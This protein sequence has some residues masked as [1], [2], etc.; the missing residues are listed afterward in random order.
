MARNIR[1]DIGIV[2][3]AKELK[4]LEKHLEEAKQGKGKLVFLTGEA[5][6]GKAHLVEAFHKHHQDEVLLVEAHVSPDKQMPYAPV[7][8]LFKNTLKL[9]IPEDGASKLRGV[10]AQYKDMAART[11]DIEGGMKQREIERLFNQGTEALTSAGKDTSLMVFMDNLQ[12]ADKDSL[13]FIHFL[14]RNTRESHIMLVCTYRPEEMEDTPEQ[15]H[16]LTETL[17]MMMM[18]DL[19]STI[20]LER[21]T[22]EE[23]EAFVS[24]L[25]EFS[26]L[27]EQFVQRVYSDT[28]GNPF[29]VRE[30]IKG[31][32]R[33]G[34]LDVE[35]EDWASKIDYDE[36]KMPSSIRE[37][38]LARVEKQEGQDADVLKTAA[39]L[40]STFRLDDLAAM[41][42]KERDDIVQ[43]LYRLTEDKIV[44]ADSDVDGLYHFDHTKIQQIIE[45]ELG[46][47]RAELHKKAGEI[48]E[49]LHSD[50]MDSVVYELAYHYSMAGVTAK[51]VRYAGLAAEK[52][53]AS[54]APDEAKRYLRMVVSALDRLEGTPENKAALARRLIHLADIE[55][56]GGEVEKALEHYTTAIVTAQESGSEELSAKAYRKLGHYHREKGKWEEAKLAYGKALEIAERIDNKEVIADTYRGLGKVKWRLGDFPGAEELYNKTIEIATGAGIKKLVGVAKIELGNVL[57]DVG[58]YEEGIVSYKES[59]DILLEL[60]DM[61]EAARAYNNMGE[62]YKHM[63]KMDMAI[64]CYEDCIETA[65]KVGDIRTMSYGLMNAAEVLAKKGELDKALDYAT[66]ALQHVKKLQE[67]YVIGGAHMVLGLIYSKKGD[68]QQARE[69]FELSLKLIREVN[70]QYDIALTLYEYG[71]YLK[72]IGKKDAREKL[73]EALNIFRDVGA[74]VY[75]ERTKKALEE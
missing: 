47:Q 34:I 13:Q 67:T 68:E 7:M 49:R 62:Q 26:P 35:D 27:P 5:G 23:V 56:S 71:S 69:H 8:T 32:V 52:A 36:L 39:V 50:E 48:T 72:S 20:P 38:I 40:G 46:E 64:Q 11:G 16:P 55:D 59:L 24:K 57:G 44:Y 51:T 4:L 58:K 31:M 41:T 14:A 21:F 2:G 25:L 73:E 28:E 66:R 63:K 17:G 75:V 60:G 33:D 10:L 61:G 3:R 19:F 9:N 6:V 45:Q 70:V 74:E 43:S 65:G 54:F 42:G 29:F 12:W 37:V 30:V 15:M 53:F 1:E 18:E 22:I